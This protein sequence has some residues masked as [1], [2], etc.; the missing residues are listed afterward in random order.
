MLFR[1]I[2]AA[3]WNAGNFG[4]LV[5]NVTEAETV[6]YLEDSSVNDQLLAGAIRY[7]VEYTTLPGDITAGN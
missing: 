5:K 6:P 1:S 2:V 7:A 4:R 3:M